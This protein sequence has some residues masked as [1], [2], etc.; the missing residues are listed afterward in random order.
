MKILIYSAEFGNYETD[1]RQ[2]V[3]PAM[4][5]NVQYIYYR[6]SEYL[7]NRDGIWY[8]MPPCNPI[9]ELRNNSQLWARFHK[10]DPVGYFHT[11]IDFDY[12]VWVD[13]N[14]QLLADPY[15]LVQMLGDADL[16]TFM[17]RH[18]TTVEEEGSTVVQIKQQNP[19]VIERQIHFQKQAGYDNFVPL[20]ETGL[21]VR[22]V[23]PRIHHFNNI[24]W[25]Q[26]TTFSIR[27]QM[28]FGYSAW[29]AGIKV[30]F[31][32]GHVRSKKYNILYPH[33]RRSCKTPQ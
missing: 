32:P 27:D 6:F 31:F 7:K 2:P 18:R 21:L 13:A 8:N 26:V 28:S 20:P 30:T 12:T 14:M 10:I 25:H 24:W 33:K 4:N 9:K 22:K 3:A 29:K 5:P 17:H 19:E 11:G 16:M 23:N 15:D 1:V